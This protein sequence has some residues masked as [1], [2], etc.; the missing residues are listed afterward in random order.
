MK[1]QVKKL[2]QLNKEAVDLLKAE[3]IADAIAKMAEV[4]ELT[5]EME[6]ATEEPAPADGGNT[7]Q[8]AIQKAETEAKSKE[9]IAKFVSLN[10]TADDIK[11]FMTQFGELKDQMTTGLETINKRV[12]T[13]ESAKG[14]QK[15]A[16]EAI[17]KGA[18][19]NVWA[20]LDL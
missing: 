8:E 16:G 5:K 7:D 6:T 19:G 15:Q 12:D 13:L 10:I 11:D 1:E 18:N 20:D 9:L 17:E 14:I 3:N 4:Q 2:A